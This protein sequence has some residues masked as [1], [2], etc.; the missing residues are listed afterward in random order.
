LNRLAVVEAFFTVTVWAALAVPTGEVKAV[1]A[2]GV[3]VTAAWA[4]PVTAMAARPAAIVNSRR[5]PARWTDRMRMRYP[6]KWIVLR[7]IRRPI[8]LKPL[9]SQDQ[10][11][12][13][14]YPD[15]NREQIQK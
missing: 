6:E 8:D 13:R 2:V 10:N 14:H 5:K 11:L 15:F 9:S 7:L 4:T 1:S 12:H 3:K